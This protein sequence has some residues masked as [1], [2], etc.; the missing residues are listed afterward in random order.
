MVSPTV[1]VVRP[2]T[3]ARSPWSSEDQREKALETWNLHYNYHRP[4]VCMMG[5]RP[6]PG[7]HHA[8]TTSSAR[9]ARRLVRGLHHGESGRTNPG[10]SLEAVGRVDLLADLLGDA[11]REAFVLRD[12]LGGV[13]A[14]LVRNQAP[15]PISATATSTAATISGRRFDLRDG[16]P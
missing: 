10:C 4:T 5:S 16:A 6:H 14:G 8:S 7:H 9:T 12:R 13:A 11:D 15:T 1:D 2:E 3:V